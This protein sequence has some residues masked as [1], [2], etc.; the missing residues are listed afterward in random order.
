MTVSP[1]G[2]PP[3]DWTKDHHRWT[4]T[5]AV[6]TT[7]LGVIR[8]HAVA[9]GIPADAHPFAQIQAL[10]DRAEQWERVAGQGGA[11]AKQEVDGAEAR[12]LA[13]QDVTVEAL[14]IYIGAIERARPWWDA[15]PMNVEA[16]QPG[17]KA[18]AELAAST[19]AKAERH[20]AGQVLNEHTG[21]L[22]SMFAQQAK[23]TVEQVAAVLPLPSQ[24][25]SAPKPA[26]VLAAATRET[27]YE[28]E[29]VFNACHY[30]AL[31]LRSM[32]VP[33]TDDQLTG[34]DPVHG[35][36][37]RRWAD[38]SEQRHELGPIHEPLK[39]AYAVEHGWEPGLWLASDLRGIDQG[40]ARRRFMPSFLVR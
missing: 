2:E 15:V 14:N 33:D 8:N 18:A 6:V 9:V 4:R 40:P 30:M 32:G 38:F 31:W 19:L 36:T 29:R 7:D 11:A 5:I 25:W 10:L 24:V 12:A 20:Q 37:F 23:H 26:N 27:L 28:A 13:S 34:D 22:Y 35:L 39:L 1:I 21:T 3:T 16:A 17:R